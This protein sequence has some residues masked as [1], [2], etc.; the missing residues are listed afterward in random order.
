MD[1]LPKADQIV[2]KVER[3]DMTYLLLQRVVRL[4][5]GVVIKVQLWLIRILKGRR[6]RSARTVFMTS[7]TRIPSEQRVTR[8][9]YRSSR[10]REGYAQRGA[11]A[12]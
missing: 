3:R 2:S 1:F 8:Y 11:H 4:H 7:G 6:D 12:R 10:Y 5:G 9:Q